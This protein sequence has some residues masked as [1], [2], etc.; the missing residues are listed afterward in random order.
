MSDTSD[1]EH[2]RQPVTIEQYTTKLEALLEADSLDITPAMK[3]ALRGIAEDGERVYLT[4]ENLRARPNDELRQ[5]HDIDSMW[6]SVRELKL[7]CPIAV[8]PVPR[9]E[10]RYKKDL[11]LRFPINDNIIVCTLFWY[12]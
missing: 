10:D 6:G 3:Y 12:N 9:K 8:W 11:G 1:I 4:T 7:N 2:Q 5:M